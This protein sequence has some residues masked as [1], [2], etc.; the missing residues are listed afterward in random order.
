[1]HKTN[2]NKELTA[3]IHNFLDRKMQEFP[4]LRDG[5]DLEDNE[6]R[7]TYAAPDEIHTRKNLTLHWHMPHMSRVSG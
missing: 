6:L 1:M 7:P 3:R 4:E 2:S 5:V